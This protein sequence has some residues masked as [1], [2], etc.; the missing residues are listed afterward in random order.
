MKIRFKKE[1]IVKDF[2]EFVEFVY[3]NKPELLMEFNK[4][5]K[6]PIKLPILE[7]YKDNKK[8]LFL[9]TGKKPKEKK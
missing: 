8:M 9:I 2:Y 4:L 7:Y 1:E 5:R 6:H 3:L